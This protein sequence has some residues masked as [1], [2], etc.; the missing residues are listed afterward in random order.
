M[1][2]LAA[3][4]MNCWMTYSSVKLS[5]W[6]D[7]LLNDLESYSVILSRCAVQTSLYNVY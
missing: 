6:A 5:L 2:Y 3:G 7:E 1:S 4:Q